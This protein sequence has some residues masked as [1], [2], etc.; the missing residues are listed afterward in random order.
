MKESGDQRALAGTV[1]HYCIGRDRCSERRARGHRLGKPRCS[2]AMNRIGDNWKDDTTPPHEASSEQRLRSRGGRIGLCGFGLKSD[3]RTGSMTSSRNAIWRGEDTTGS[4]NSSGMTEISRAR[5]SRHHRGRLPRR[6]RCAVRLALFL[7]ATAP[8]YPAGTGAAEQRDFGR[9][10]DGWLDAV[11]GC[12]RL[13]DDRACVCWWLAYRFKSAVSR[14][15]VS[16][17][18][19]LGLGLLMQASTWMSR[20]PAEDPGRREGALQLAAGQCEIID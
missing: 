5:R 18:L 11:R 4:P 8:L 2:A 16:A 6:G 15:S 9:D 10:L 13:H 12:R 19:Q 14:E 1:D 20:N 7:I 3:R 17:A